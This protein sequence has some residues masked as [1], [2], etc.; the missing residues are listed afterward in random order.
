MKIDCSRRANTRNRQTN[1]V[2]LKS[3]YT[4][5]LPVTSAEYK[6]LMSLCE[7]DLIPL[8]YHIVYKKIKHTTIDNI[9]SNEEDY[10]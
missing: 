8:R 10:Y 1:V 6:D 3:A 4:G 7:Q 2:A 5:V 9:F